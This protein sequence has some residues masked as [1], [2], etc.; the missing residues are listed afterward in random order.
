MLFGNWTSS[1]LRYI[2]SRFIGRVLVITL[3]CSVA[4]ECGCINLPMISG[5]VT[6]LVGAA[7]CCIANVQYQP[8]FDNRL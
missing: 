2:N 6:V 5:N 3:H 8:S 1:P 4:T 7:Y